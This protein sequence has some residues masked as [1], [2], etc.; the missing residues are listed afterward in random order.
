MLDYSCDAY[1]I[2]TDWG[3]T[4]YYYSPE[5]KLNPRNFSH[6]IFNYFN[7]Y[8]KHARAPYLKYVYNGPTFKMTLVATEVKKEDLDE[9]AFSAVWEEPKEISDAEI[10]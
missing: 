5:L 6:H 2:Q 1:S 9:T 7:I 4:T 3:L 10:K 8:V